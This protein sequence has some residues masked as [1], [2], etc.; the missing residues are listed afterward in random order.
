MAGLDHELLVGCAECDEILRLGFDVAS[1]RL[2]QRPLQRIDA[3]KA[4]WLVVFAGGE[5][6]FALEDVQGGGRVSAWRRDATG[7]FIAGA[8][9]PSEGV[10]AV[11]GSLGAEARHLLVA[12][13]CADAL[14]G[15][16]LAVLPVSA[17]GLGR[18]T[19]LLAEP[20][21]RPGAQ[22]QASSHIHCVVVAPGGRQVFACDLGADRLYHY[23]YRAEDG[24]PLAPVNPRYLQLP[25]G[26]GP[27]HLLF[28]ASGRHAYLTLELSNQVALL[29]YQNDRLSL[30]TLYDLDPTLQPPADRRLGA[31]HLS[32]DGRFLYVSRRGAENQLVVYAVDPSDGTLEELQRRDSGGV[33]PREFALAPDGRF[34]LV[35]NQRSD[36]L[37]VIRRDPASG[38]LGDTLQE[39][40]V[41]SPSD[42]KFIAAVAHG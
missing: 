41:P 30:R 27:R 12:H 19:Q 20:F 24:A 8:S 11:H 35:A 3:S 36:N 40:N 34:L 25:E 6:L 23:H 28:D 9:M 39:L 17:D 15:G 10:E 2:E 38:L 26:S 33:E 42:L 32:A 29:D 18:V 37:L 4:S 13:Y 1:G 31:L 14:P 7:Q 16:S 21:E 5:R 22:R